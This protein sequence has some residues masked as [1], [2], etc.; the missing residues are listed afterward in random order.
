MN[1]FDLIR[2]GSGEAMTAAEVALNRGE[3]VVMPTDTVYGVAARPDLT[4]ATRRV[5]DAKLRPTNLTL[6]VLAHSAPA[7]EAV[8]ELD[9]RARLLA[10]RFWPGGLTIVLPRAPAAGA[11]NLGEET[12]TVGVRVPA[13]DVALGLLGRTGPLAV[14]SANLSGEA[15]PPDCDGVRAVLGETVAV[16]LCAG[17]CEGRPSTVVDLIGAEPIIRREGAVVAADIRAALAGED[18]RRRR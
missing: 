18:V 4:G 13:H 8:A 5:F 17:R 15:T 16:Y 2:T 9:D 3:L 14:T 6:P 10:T 11:W 12:E 7:A 1:V